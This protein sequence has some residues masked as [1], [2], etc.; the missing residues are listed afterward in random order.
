MIA[1]IRVRFPS[2]LPKWVWTDAVMDAWMNPSIPFSLAHYWTRTSLFQADMRY[3]LFPPIVINDARPTAN[4]PTQD[5][6]RQVLVDSALAEITRLYGNNWNDF[7]RAIL[8]FAQATDLFGGGS[9]QVPVGD[10][11]PKSIPA[12]VCDI[13]SS[14]DQVVQEVGHTFGLNHEVDTLGNEY[15]SP[16][17]CM[18][19]QRYG[20]AVPGPSFHRPVDN[21][22]PRGT[23][24]NQ[25]DTQLTVGPYMTPSQF[26]VNTLMPTF[27]DPNTVY[28]V[29]ASYET[30]PHTFRITAVDVAIDSWPAR[31]PI[32][33]V[34]QPAAGGDLYFFELRRSNSYDAGLT[35]D[36]SNGAPIAVAVHAYSPVTGRVRYLNKMSLAGVPGD[37]DYHSYAGHFTVRL[38]SF[39]NDFSSCSLTVGGNDFW[40]YFGVTFDNVITLTLDDNFSGWETAD[41]SP[42][43]MFTKSPHQF[44][45]HSKTTQI[46]FTASSFGYEKPNYQWFINDQYLDPANPQLQFQSSVKSFLHGVP[47]DPADQNVAVKYIQKQNSI[48]LT[49]EQAFAGVYATVKVIVNESSSEV[50]QN[51]YPDRSVWTGIAF[52][53]VSVQWDQSYI[54]ELKA[55]VKRIK[56]IND[57]YS[58]SQRP[59]HRRDPGPQF[60]VDTITLINELVATN[61]AAANAVIN[62]VA[63][64][65]N[66]SKLEI[67]KKLTG[68]DT[69]SKD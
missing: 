53:N 51:L 60:G 5:Q 4:P 28:R 21:R 10:G 39:E 19:S 50:V 47:T 18:S 62:E 45:Y 14:F 61:P 55:C 43:F 67:L 40:K 32:L 8:V 49:F 56:D 69:M 7:D 33:A 26:F 38:N 68:A 64:L 34:L 6:Q 46:T 11:P 1:L 54:D 22:L 37:R 63:R 29:P 15:M 35:L 36:G 65:G 3:H 23:D 25:F 42:C 41:V 20:N 30:A 44:R 24:A 12:A 16:Y 48:Q 52:D 66:I 9:H 59:I 17:S 58:I 57:H 2:T 31:K 13:A 27:Q